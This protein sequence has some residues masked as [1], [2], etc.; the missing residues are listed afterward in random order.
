VG[1]PFFPTRVTGTFLRSSTPSRAQSAKQKKRTTTKWQEEKHR[2]KSRESDRQFIGGT[3]F[4]SST[5]D[6]NENG[7]NRESGEMEENMIEYQNVLEY[8][9]GPVSHAENENDRETEDESSSLHAPLVRKML[10]FL[11]S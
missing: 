11:I 6:H 3:G 9:A 10:F 1:T 4:N 8:G 2:V 5:M 7:E